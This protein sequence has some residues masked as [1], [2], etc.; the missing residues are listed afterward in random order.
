MWTEEKL[1]ALLTTPSDGLIRDMRQCEGDLMIL[2][3]GGKMGP[4]LAILARKALDAAGRKNRVLAVSRFSDQDALQLLRSH[5]VETISCDLMKEG[6][7]EA[8][9]D[10]ENIIYMAGRKF[11]TDGQKTLTWAMNA[12][13]PSR[14][15]E[16]FKHAR[17]VVFSSGNVYPKL[18]LAS[19]GATEEV[20]PAPVG[21]YDMSC[22]ARERMFEYAA[23]TYGTKIALFRLNYAID[24]R[25]GVLYDIA[26]KILTGQP[27][28][29]SMP[30]FNCIWQGS[31][32]EAALR[33]LRHC[34]SDVFRLNVTGP[35]TVSTEKT[36]RELARL[37]GREVAFCGQPEETALLNDA[38]RMQALFGYPAVPVGTLIAWQAQWLLAGGRTLNKPTHFEERKGSY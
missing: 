26:R 32:N 38:S 5:G 16:R 37:L 6:A 24:L 23:Q 15:A 7:L 14:V 35:E 12:W 33:L 28:S 8:L 11:G 22:L 30:C 3:A 25:Y 4:S 29:L 1:D 36:A 34:S 17:I 19:G 18:P 20:R 27:V 13:L 9:P 10:C 21:D 2:G 31:A